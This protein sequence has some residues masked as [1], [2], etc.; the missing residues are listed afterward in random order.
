MAVKDYIAGSK[1]VHSLE[2]KRHRVSKCGAEASS[3]SAMPSWLICFYNV[4]MENNLT[5]DGKRLDSLLVIML[6]AG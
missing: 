2:Q 1:I 5:Y 6:K 4:K 3:G